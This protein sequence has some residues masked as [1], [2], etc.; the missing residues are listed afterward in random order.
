LDSVYYYCHRLSILQ[1]SLHIREKL[2]LNKISNH[3][4]VALND[5][6]IS[7]E[8]FSL[9]LSGENNF[10]E[11]KEK[12]RSKSKENTDLESEIVKPRLQRMQTLKWR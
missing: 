1:T 6:K 11:T 2:I 12:L 5:S 9:I 8:E 7:A 10:L 3:I 4:S